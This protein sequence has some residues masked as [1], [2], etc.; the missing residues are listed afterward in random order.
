MGFRASAVASHAGASRASVG[1]AERI[2]RFRRFGVPTFA[3][4]LSVAKAAEF[5]KPDARRWRDLRP[6]SGSR[7]ACEVRRAIGGVPGDS[8]MKVTTSPASSAF[9]VMISSLSAHFSIL[10][11]GVKTKDAERSARGFR[12]RPAD[13]GTEGEVSRGA[14]GREAARIARFVERACRRSVPRERPR[15]PRSRPPPSV[16]PGGVSSSR[17]LEHRRAHFQTTLFPSAIPKRQ[18]PSKGERGQATDAKPPKIARIHDTGRTM[19]VRF[20]PMVMLRSQR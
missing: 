19:L 18:V 9:M 4:V 20:M 15:D 8:N 3:F 5:E 2:K 14:G 16:V 11:C 6:G 10:D 1:L 13:D 17:G 12:G 7:V